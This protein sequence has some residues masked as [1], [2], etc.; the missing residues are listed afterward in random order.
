MGVGLPRSLD[1]SLRHLDL[2]LGPHRHELH[3]AAPEK[4][5][6]FRQL[7][8]QALLDALELTLV[9]VED[10]ALAGRRLM[11]ARNWVVG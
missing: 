3:L 8:P 10:L 1:G 7:C 6:P 5:A 4:L 2:V 11:M 9:F